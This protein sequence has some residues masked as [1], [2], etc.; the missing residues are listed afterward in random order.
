MGKCDIINCN[1]DFFVFK[2]GY[3][4]SIGICEEHLQ[5]LKNKQI[6]LND[7]FNKLTVLN[8]GEDKKYM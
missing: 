3:G 4:K 7:L 1:N 8:I 5:K 2:Y 6:T